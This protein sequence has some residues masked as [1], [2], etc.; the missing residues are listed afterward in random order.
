VVMEIY[1]G[2]NIIRIQVFDVVVVPISDM[3]T[4]IQRNQCNV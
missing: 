4:E 1:K 3:N 2:C